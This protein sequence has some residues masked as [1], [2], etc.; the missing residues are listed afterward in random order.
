MVEAPEDFLTL[1]DRLRWLVDRSGL[2][3]G[4]FAEG[5]GITEGMLS[6][7]VNNKAKPRRSNL[8]GVA[9]LFHSP[10][11]RMVTFLE[12]GGP[13]PP[14]GQVKTNGAPDR[15]PPRFTKEGMQPLYI[16]GGPSTW[17]KD[18]A[19]TT[20][21]WSEEEPDGYVPAMPN[22]E[23]SFAVT[24]DGHSMAPRLRHGE[25]VT[26]ADVGIENIQDGHIVFVRFRQSAENCIRLAFKE[27]DG[28]IR[29]AP[30]NPDKAHYPVRHVMPDEVQMYRVVGRW[31]PL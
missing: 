13:A 22:F 27:A 16:G 24:I 23:H 6:Q 15:P 7:W 9:R 1:G 28:R 18:V 10:V 26:V 30:W 3:Q 5:I 19:T 21:F 31:E 25:V 2:T 4:D 11:G 8:A 12:E 17:G 29:L 20:G 14:L